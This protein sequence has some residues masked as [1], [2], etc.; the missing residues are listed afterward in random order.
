M[1]QEQ[2]DKIKRFAKE[3]PWAVGLIL[4]G[5]VVAVYLLFFRKRG[6]Q[7]AGM[8]Y[9][10]GESGLPAAAGGGGGEGSGVDQISII[11]NML[12]K[13]MENIGESNKAMQEYTGQILSS[14][15]LMMAEMTASNMAYLE[16]FLQQQKI[17]QLDFLAGLSR[18]MPTIPV[19]DLHLPAGLEFTGGGGSDYYGL[20]GASPGTYRV[21]ATFGS[22][23]AVVDEAGNVTVDAG[24]YKPYADAVDPASG[25]PLSDLFGRTSSGSSGGGGGSTKTGSGSTG[26]GSSGSS[27]SRTVVYWKDSK[28]NTGA[29]SASSVPKGAT[30]THTREVPYN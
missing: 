16:N 2:W 21:D 18:M 4:A 29:G 9:G 13:T 15:Q 12:E 24:T 14:T 27:G 11:G 6:P 25:K 7:A 5:L 17:N 10:P 19:P 23:T 1:V 3:K 22:F 26:S 8:F 30:V 28:G 20:K